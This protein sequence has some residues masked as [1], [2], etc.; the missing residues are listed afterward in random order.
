MKKTWK[1]KGLAV[2]LE[3]IGILSTLGGD[4]T[5]FLFFSMISIPLFFAKE[6]LFAKDN[7]D[8]II[9]KDGEIHKLNKWEG[10]NICSENS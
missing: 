2:F 1:N 9:G 5:A 3:T 8:Y 10:V 7:A 6:S 4:F